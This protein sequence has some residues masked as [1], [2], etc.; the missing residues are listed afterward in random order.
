M[1][2]KNI[3]FILFFC[4]F[5]AGSAFSEIIVLKSG[6]EVEGKL[7]EKT[8]EYVKINFQG[9]ELV[10]YLDEIAAIKDSKSPSTGEG[11]SYNLNSAYPNID[12]SA[13]AEH[14][15]EKS[16]NNSVQPEQSVNAQAPSI[17][18]PQS[19]NVPGEGAGVERAIKDLPKEYQEM[20][21]SAMKDLPKSSND[22]NAVSN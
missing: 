21:E 18:Q 20:V 11:Q 5:F 2:P 4:L 16:S 3:S 14:Y 22:K 1:N 19:Q 12:Y 6:G 10:Y 17:N 9:V 7:I 8:D 15:S 13:L